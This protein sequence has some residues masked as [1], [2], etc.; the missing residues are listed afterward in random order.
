MKIQQDYD[1]QPMI[2]IIETAEELN[3]FRDLLDH[4]S[5]KRPADQ[6]EM[7]CLLSDW[8]CNRPT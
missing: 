4:G 1:F 6:R 7:A 8:I 2:I 5:K 3:T